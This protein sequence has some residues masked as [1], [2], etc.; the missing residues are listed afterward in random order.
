MNKLNKNDQVEQENEHAEQKKIQK[1]VE[2]ENE[3]TE[4][5]QENEQVEQE[6]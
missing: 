4:Q 2:Q 1:Q 3:Q 6:N 5:E